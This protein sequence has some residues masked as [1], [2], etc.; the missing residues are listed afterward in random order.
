MTG[1]IVSYVIREDKQQRF[2]VSDTVIMLYLETWKVQPLFQTVTGINIR[3]RIFHATK[4]Y[5]CWNNAMPRQYCNVT[6]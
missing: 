3:N 2:G 6:R 1:Q 4:L 5:K